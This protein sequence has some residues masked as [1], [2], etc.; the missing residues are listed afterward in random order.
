MR[1]QEVEHRRNDGHFGIKMP[2]LR[3]TI[4]LL[5]AATLLLAAP[6]CR[7][8]A[9]HP[10]EPA[11]AASPEQIERGRYL[12]SAVT[13]CIDCHSQ[14]DY[15]QLGGPVVPGTEYSGGMIFD[16]DFFFQGQL[17]PGRI[18]PPN[19]TQEPETGIGA[20]TDVEILKAIRQGVNREGEPLFPLMPYPNYRHLTSEDGLAISAYM[21]TI[22]AR[23]NHTIPR[24]LGIPTTAY[25]YPT[26][27]E[28]EQLPM[29]P[30]A[31]GS[32]QRGRYL[33][34]ISGCGDCHT[35]QA[36]D[37]QLDPERH[38]AGGVVIRTPEWEVIATNLTPDPETGLGRV[39]RTQFMRA[40]RFG[41]AIAVP[42]AGIHPIMPWIFYRDMT[43]DDL[44][45]MWAYLQSIP[46]IYNPMG[47]RTMP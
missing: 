8:R 34:T 29:N 7:P 35:P 23:F 21:R 15:S 14:R 11:P 2:R 18:Q 40:M 47:G 24:Q 4:I 20:W 16:Q 28:L 31:P 32:V 13:L 45:A 41:E 22:P 26:G 5:V 39:S 19:I 12:T 3:R 38:L 9:L 25:P 27:E 42:D 10:A 37:G 1:T 36:A 30:G 46:A 17:L 44:H 43:D 6:S 33:T